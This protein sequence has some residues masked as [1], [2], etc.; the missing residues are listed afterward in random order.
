[1]SLRA[2]G[3]L[4]ASKV[5]SDITK[6]SPSKASRY[7]TTIE[8]VSDNEALSLVVEGEMTKSQYVL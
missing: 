5:I 6:G 2:S 4:Q 1:M 3:N 8:R 7:R